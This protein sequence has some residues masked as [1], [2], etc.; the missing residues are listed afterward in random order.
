MRI[1]QKS[2]FQVTHDV[3]RLHK[4]SG[5]MGFK[6]ETNPRKARNVVR[7]QVTTMKD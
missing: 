1:M 3:F 7:S 6:T 4:E 2:K 5:M